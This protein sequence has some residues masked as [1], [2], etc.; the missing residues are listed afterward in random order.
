M[1]VDQETRQRISNLERQVKALM[2]FVE[3]PEPSEIEGLSEETM[4]AVRAGDSM[5]AV[6]GIRND[7]TCDLTEAQRIYSEAF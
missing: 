2:K 3:M 1:S 7:L 6:K 5:K 4:A